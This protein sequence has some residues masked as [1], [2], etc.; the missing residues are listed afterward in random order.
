MK[1]KFNFIRAFEILY[2]SVSSAYLSI[3]LEHDP[4]HINSNH[5]L[6]MAVFDRFQAG[7]QNFILVCGVTCSLY[8]FWHNGQL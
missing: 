5:V 8:K 4:L 1:F 2:L 7:L 3:A 6:G